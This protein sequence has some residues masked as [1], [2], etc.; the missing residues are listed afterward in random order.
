[1]SSVVRNAVVIK[2]AQKGRLLASEVFP[3]PSNQ[4]IYMNDQLHRDT[5]ILMGKARDAAKHLGL[6]FLQGL[7]S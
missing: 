1:M 3:G 5:Y 7:L 4:Q 6:L 2:E